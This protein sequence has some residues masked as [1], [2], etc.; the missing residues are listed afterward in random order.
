MVANAN[1]EKQLVSEG[2]NYIAG[3]DETGMGSLAGDVYVAA[4]VFPA[5]FDFSLLKGVDDS[6]KKSEAQRKALSDLIKKHALTYAVATASVEEIDTHNIYWAR[7][8]A[9]RR[10][11]DALSVR[12]D[13]VLIDGNAT[14][15]EVEMQQKAIVKGDGISISIAAASIL[16]KVERDEY[17]VSLA[18]KVHDDYGWEGN[19]AY[20]TPNHIKALQKHGKTKWH[21]HKFVKKFLGASDEKIS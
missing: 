13:Y 18:N 2:Y 12:P 15:P 16:A 14:I 5:D 10:A 20:Y 9:A 8:I 19:K 1:E 3:V 21:R 6:K 11:L 7:F 4:V 17:I